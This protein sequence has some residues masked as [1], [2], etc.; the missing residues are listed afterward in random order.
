MNFTTLGLSIKKKKI[1]IMKLNLVKKDNLL[2]IIMKINNKFVYDYYNNSGI[3]YI[4]LS[5]ILK[6]FIPN[7]S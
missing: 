2:F 5:L 3:C 7:L 4:F 6:L 1:M